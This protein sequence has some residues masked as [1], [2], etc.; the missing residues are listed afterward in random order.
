MYSKN[1]A[2][3]K[4]AQQSDWL[5]HW[6]RAREELDRA[7]WASSCCARH[8]HVELAQLHIQRLKIA[9]MRPPDA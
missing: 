8:P 5:H 4:L 6:T 9:P 7:R 1:A 3:A 2:G